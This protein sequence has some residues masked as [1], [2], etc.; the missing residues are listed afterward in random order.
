[1]TGHPRQPGPSGT[2][3]RPAGTWA[4]T[5]LSLALILFLALSLRLWG[6]TFGLPNPY[7]RPDEDI[8]VTKA[9][10]F[11]TAG[12]LN[13]H[14]FSY[15][16]L[17]MYLTYACYLAYGALG[18]LV[19]AY[20]S[21]A[22]FFASYDHDPTIFF[23]IPRLISGVLG[24]ATV[25]IVFAIGRR[26]Y[27]IRTG[28][29][30]AFFLALN[31]LHARESHYGVTDSTLVFFIMLSALFLLRGRDRAS[32]W[33]F[34][35]AGLFAGFATSTKYAG[36]F[37]LAPMAVIHLQHTLARPERATIRCQTF[38]AD[39]RLW[40]FMGALAFGAWLGTPY[41][42]FD[43]KT[44]IDNTTMEMAF[45]SQ[46]Y[47]LVTHRGWKYHLLFSLPHGLGLAMLLASALGC[48]LILRDS[49]LRPKSSEKLWAGAF[50]AF[51]IVYYFIAGRS[52][53]V[54]ARYILPIVPFLT[55]AAAVLVWRITDRLGKRTITP[56]V[57][58]GLVLLLIAQSLYNLIRCDLLLAAKDNRLLAAQWVCDHLPN[59]SSIYQT[60]N[61]W[62]ELKLPPSLSSLEQAVALTSEP[63][64]QA[65]WRRRLEVRQAE[66][67][68]GFDL[69]SY[70]PDT[71][72]F[73]FL[74]RDR[75]GQPDFIIVDRSALFR[76]DRIDRVLP[77]LKARLDRDY[78]L[79]Q[80][81]IALNPDNPHNLFDQTDAFYLPYAGFREISRPG[82]NF[83]IYTRKPHQQ[84]ASPPQP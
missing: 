64:E 11:Y 34:A 79:I 31:Y 43:Y 14:W 28:L 29:L 32:A 7:C 10:G 37:M 62:A 50:L 76:F 12:D 51:P 54:F 33:D 66:G 21:L 77:A 49:Y 1:M 26:L 61:I 52:L 30:A 36:I 81:F 71:D 82:P 73:H 48:L 60:A 80:E 19:G 47:L 22:G 2:A 57:T 69:W 59:G 18:T 78:T 9:I 16:S 84:A 70:N 40:V 6:V 63:D 67:G 39:R 56:F 55:V 5:G 75:A 15:P 13:P 4:R 72:T 65:Q 38:W 58:A 25:G 35:W 24:T 68:P 41:S 46:G 53:I 42:L 20:D 23:L 17:L 45:Q 83:H 3:P 74:G 27:D 8:I 44:F